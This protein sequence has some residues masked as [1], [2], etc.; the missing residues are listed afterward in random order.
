MSRWT[1]LGPGIRRDAS[2]IEAR[3]KVRGTP[4][5]ARFPAATPLVTV[6]QW[7][8]TERKALQQA[9]PYDRT[10]RGRPSTTGGTLEAATQ[11]FLPQIA[12]RASFKAD[13]SHLRAWFTVVGHHPRPL[14]EVS[15][16]LIT[17]EDVNLAIAQWQTAPSRRDVRRIRVTGYAR[18][19][20]RAVGSPREAVIRAYDRQ[21]PV[22][23]GQV[24]AAKT[25]RHRCRML[26]ELYR[27]L[28]PGAPSPVQGAKIPKLPKP[29]P[30][31]M[32]IETVRLVARTLARAAATAPDH[33]KTFARFAVLATTGQRPCQVMRTQ[34]DDLQRDAGLWIVRSAKNEPVHTITLNADMI[35]A[36]DLFVAAEAW[37]AYDTTQHARRV[38]AA[39]WPKGVRPY[40]ARH[41]VMIDALAAGV[42]LDDVQGLAGHTS[43]LTTRTFY[44]P[45][46][47]S[48]QRQVS[49][50]LTGRLA[51]VFGPRLVK[52]SPPAR[53]GVLPPEFTTH[54]GG[55]HSKRLKNI[56]LPQKRTQK[57]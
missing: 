47:V 44:G 3:V 4:R 56:G 35:A 40:A 51:G 33:A 15:I 29:H 48:R 45:L 55:K 20:A 13:R 7:Q 52:K 9:D 39:G 49:D 2:G 6:E 38:H 34:P 32:P 25:I 12:G 54:A 27:T 41:A 28:R 43:P 14:G 30:V 5:Y 36:W 16:D 23:S 31:G 1:I 57:A 42:R 21:T 19:T 50:A 53:A 26:G 22:T 8:E 18:E 17:S 37:G 24:V 11:R 46:T 10:R